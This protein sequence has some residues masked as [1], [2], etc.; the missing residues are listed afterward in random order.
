MIQRPS[1]ILRM[2]LAGLSLALLAGC[3]SGRSGDLEEK[4]ARAE[5]AAQRAEAAQKAAETAA[6][7]AVAFG[8]KSGGFGPDDNPPSEAERADEKASMDPNSAYFDNSVGSPEG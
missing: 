1:H 7:K 5:Q 4:L 2:T 8:S 6:Q 3:G